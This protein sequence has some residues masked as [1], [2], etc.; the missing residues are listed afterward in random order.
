MI[1]ISDVLLGPD[2]EESVLSVLRSGR[3]TQGPKVSELEAA[4][5]SMCGVRH[6]VAVNNGTT[7]LVAAFRV[8]D[9]G[10]GD[11]VIVPAFTFVATANAALETGATVRLV[12]IDSSDFCIDTGAMSEAVTSRTAAVVPVHLFGHPADL[13]KIAPFAEEQ[14]LRIVEDAAQAHGA[15]FAG[16]PVGGFGTG[17]FSFYATK[18]LA[19]GEG[20]I[21]TTDDDEV[22]ERL[23]VLRN[24][25]MRVRYEYE[26][27]GNNY[28]MT[29]LAAA[30]VLPQL[31]RYCQQVER[32]RANA[33]VLAELLHDLPE[34]ALPTVAAERTHVWHQ[35][36]V[37]VLASLSRDELADRLREQGVASG[38]YYPK[39]LQQYDCYR[40]HPRVIADP[41]PTADAVAST[42]LS[43][44]VHAGLTSTD[45]TEIAA[46]VR[47]ALRPPR[48]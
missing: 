40:E 2:V 15:S 36:T 28:R 12:D 16:R 11:E 25:G 13:G 9:I 26:V 20:G 14:G 33:R 31:A 34:L 46:A 10:P 37:R 19:A 41:T 48:T 24:Q 23:R 44:P 5:A 6:A 17:C 4:F 42:C 27:V 45:L 43:L 29:D 30:V 35:Y 18:N 8:L 21:V 32:R 1:E 38:V 3:L 7:A 39:P 22:A 47:R